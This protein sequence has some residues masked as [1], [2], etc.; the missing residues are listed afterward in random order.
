[1]ITPAVSTPTKSSTHQNILGELPQ[2]V[3]SVVRWSTPVIMCVNLFQHVDT[4]PE[5]TTLNCFKYKDALGRTQ[6]VFIT[7]EIG[8]SW[9]RVG[10]SLNF[11]ASSLDSIESTCR[12]DV[13]KCC[14]RLLTMWLEGQ[15]Q[16]VSQAPIT[17][18]TL[19]E[20][21]RDS[22]LGQLADKLTDLLTSRE[23]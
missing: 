9:N 22:R 14:N 16:D 2:C 5:I 3:C 1:M 15:V 21:L 7:D 4:K 12:G 8:T 17:W 10:L 19:L 23:N 11:T 6:R 13:V 20:A 18:E